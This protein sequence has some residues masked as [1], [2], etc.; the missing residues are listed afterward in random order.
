MSCRPRCPADRIRLACVLLLHAGLA[1]GADRIILVDGTEVEGTIT[2]LSPNDIEIA[3]G[4]GAAAERITIAAVREVRFEDEPES[5]ASSRVLLQRRD[6]RAARDELAKI[7]PVELQEGV[8]GSRVRQ[9]YE[10]LKTAAAALA[11]DP[12]GAPAA[13]AAFAAFLDRN[14]RS[15]H[16]YEGQELLG[17]LLAAAGNPDGAKAAYRQ[18]D[19]GPPALRVRSANLRAELLVRQE[20]DAGAVRE[21][22]AA[23]G[24]PPPDGTAEDSDGEHQAAR[25]ALARYES[26]RST[27]ALGRARCLARTGRAAEAITAV[28]D[29]ILAADPEDRA[30]LAAAYG[31]LGECQK[32]APDSKTDAL[33]S[34]LTVDLVYNTVPEWHARALFNLV[35]LW[36]ASNQPERSR[37]AAAMLRSTYPESPWTKRLTGGDDAS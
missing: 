21:F 10:Y 17:D 18:L 5:L 12:A 32:D 2:S 9:E 1:V 29:V 23:V 30:L 33:I 4:R 19:L 13:T 22:A 27:A 3:S 28:R 25:L 37:Q 8:V 14:A 20:N 34:Y 15:H 35:E 16:F 7:L 26:E 6:A 36:Q 31:S 24:I 11:A